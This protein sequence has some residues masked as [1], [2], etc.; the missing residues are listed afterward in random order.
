MNDSEF[1]HNVKREHPL[2]PTPKSEQPPPADC[3]AR[4]VG[5]LVSS[6]EVVE[7]Y[8]SYSK[9]FKDGEYTEESLSDAGWLALVGIP[10]LIE[11]CNQDRRDN[12]HDRNNDG[13]PRTNSIGSSPSPL[14]FVLPDKSSSHSHLLI[15]AANPFTNLLVRHL[16]KAIGIFGF[17]LRVHDSLFLTNVERT[18]GARKEGL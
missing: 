10:T 14:K 8:K 2:P 7:R 18:H 6:D 15:E 17:G 13:N 1:L 16:A 9:L 5:R 4:L 3:S 11:N 12:S